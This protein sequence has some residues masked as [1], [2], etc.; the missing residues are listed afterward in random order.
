MRIGWVLLAFLVGCGPDSPST[1][2]FEGLD[3]MGSDDCYGFVL[4]ADKMLCAAETLWPGKRL[5]GWQVEVVD[6]PIDYPVTGADVGGLTMCWGRM[7][8]QRSGEWRFGALSHEIA[9][10]FECPLGDFTHESWK[11]NGIQAAIDRANQP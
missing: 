9:H 3:M 7:V 10:A 6:G 11:T 8:V 1:C 2:V 4:Q 5:Q